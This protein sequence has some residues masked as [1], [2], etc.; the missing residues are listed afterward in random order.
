MTS[1]LYLK[2]KQS[3]TYVLYYYSIHINYTNSIISFHIISLL[4]PEENQL[5]QILKPTLKVS[6][7]TKVIVFKIKMDV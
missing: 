2:P 6:T 5:I 3:D 4:V 1:Q 7:S